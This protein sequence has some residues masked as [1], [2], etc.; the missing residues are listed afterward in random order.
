MF[1]EKIFPGRA[2]LAVLFS[3]LALFGE[4]LS[5]Q[6]PSSQSSSNSPSSLAE[7]EFPVVMRQNVVAGTTPVGTEIQAMLAVATLVNG[8]VIPQ[9]AILSGEIVESVAKTTSGPSRLAVL[10]ESAQWKEGTSPTAFQFNTKVYLTAWYYPE[11]PLSPYLLSSQAG[12]AA[13]VPS[14]HGNGASN[15]PNPTSRAPNTTSVRP[16]PSNDVDRNG[17][18]SSPASGVSQYRLLMKDIESAR[19]SEG[20]VTLTSTHSNI[21]LNK[22][23]TYVFAAGVFAGGPG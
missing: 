12:V 16:F 5:G 23:T 6:S 21:K 17:D 19:D 2:V 15:Y 22:R 3:L 4:S 7:L 10:M 14:R 20:G 1:A 18:S 8:V 9:H 11:A 13:S